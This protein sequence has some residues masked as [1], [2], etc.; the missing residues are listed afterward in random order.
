MISPWDSLRLMV[1]G[2]R[3]ELG[4]EVSSFFDW[5]LKL[6]YIIVGLLQR[7]GIRLLPWRMTRLTPWSQF[8]LGPCTETSKNIIPIRDN[9]RFQIQYSQSEN[10]YKPIS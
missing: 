9:V 6:P 1:V 2:K 8:R 5:R 7:A 4:V 3:I 10:I